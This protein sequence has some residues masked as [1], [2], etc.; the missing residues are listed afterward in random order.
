MKADR[1]LY[2]MLLKHNVDHP[3]LLEALKGFTFEKFIA[4]KEQWLK[5]VH[6]E[7]L[8]MGHLT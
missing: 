5:N 4:Q 8:I 2:N 7:W 1:K 3:E 6:T